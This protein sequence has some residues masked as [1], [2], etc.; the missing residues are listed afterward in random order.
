MDF[1]LTPEIIRAGLLLYLLLVVTLCLRAY[2]QAW[3]AHRLG[4]STADQ[5]GRLTL[6]PLPHL[7]LIGSVILPLIC[8]FYLQPRLGGL[9]F[10]LAWAKPVPV[11]PANFK[12]PNRDFLFTQLANPVMSLMLALLAAVAGGMLY[13]VNPRTAEIF[14]SLIVLNASLVVIDFLPIPPLPGAMVL[15]QFGVISEA[16]FWQISRWG[17]LVLIIAFQIPFVR[18]LLSVMIQVVAYPFMLVLQLIA[19]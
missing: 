5:N 14:A 6:N 2:A 16:A 17:G 10:F 7:D 11:N 4:D 18:G 15:R 19:Q 8:I 12:N 1:G 13:G 3:M 9:S